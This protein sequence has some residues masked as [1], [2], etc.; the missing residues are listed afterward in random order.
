MKEVMTRSWRS[1]ALLLCS[2]ALPAAPALAAQ[3]TEATMFGHITHES[4]AVLPGLS[5][6]ITSP[7]L[8]VKEMVAVTD[9]RGEYRVTPLPIGTYNVDFALPGFQTQR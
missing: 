9:A 3:S 7:A 2:D 6:T 1:V 5:V 4:A 8:L